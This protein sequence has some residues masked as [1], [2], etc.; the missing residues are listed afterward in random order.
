MDQ[1]ISIEKD[2][3]V[4]IEF[5][6]MSD[7]TIETTNVIVYDEKDNSASRYL[8]EITPGNSVI[9]FSPIGFVQSDVDY[10]KITGFNVRLYTVPLK[11]A[12]GA[13]IEIGNVYKFNNQFEYYQYLEERKIT[14]NESFK[15][16]K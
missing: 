6:N 10:S 13:D 2:D 12:V 3:I 1:L 8:T 5:K 11:Y 14:G 16:K 4:L 9:F 15:Y 7:I